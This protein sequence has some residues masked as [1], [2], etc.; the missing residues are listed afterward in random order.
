MRW[1]SLPCTK[2]SDLNWVS[3]LPEKEGPPILWNLDLGLDF[4]LEDELFF[5]ALKLALSLFSETVWPQYRENTAGVTL[6]RGPLDFSA[7]FQWTP[8]QEENW[9]LWKEDRPD[10]P[11]A[12]LKRLFCADAYAYY[13]QKLS[14]ALLDELPIFLLF[15]PVAG[16][17]NAEMLQLLSKERYEHFQ[18]VARGVCGWDGLRLEGNAFL[19]PLLSSVAI[20]LPEER[21]LNTQILEKIDRLLKELSSPL[22]V[23]PEHFLLESW[24]GVE[25]L[26][27]FPEG[28]SPQGI[29]KLKGFLASGGKVIER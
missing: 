12:Q 15:D 22:R 6:Y 18:V 24:E 17:T 8:H 27:V 3:L 19:P 1:I 4:P 29:R 25:E 21:L 16:L 7:E 28:V 2:E 5:H 9:E 23:I 13:F 20:C 11:L 26:Y 10:L 14:H